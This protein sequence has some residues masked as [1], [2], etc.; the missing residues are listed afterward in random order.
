[1][2][3]EST[4]RRS[5]KASLLTALSLIVLATSLAGCVVYPG[6]GGYRVE[7]LIAFRSPIVVR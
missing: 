1:M 6:R 5:A 7:P 3:D 4:Y 2:R